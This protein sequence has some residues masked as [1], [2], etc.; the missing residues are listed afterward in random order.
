MTYINCKRAT[1]N[2]LTTKFCIISIIT[3]VGH[4]ICHSLARNSEQFCRLTSSIQNTTWCYYVWNAEQVVFTE[5]NVRRNGKHIFYTRSITIAIWETDP[6]H[7][8]HACGTYPLRFAL[9]LHSLN[10]TGLAHFWCFCDC[11]WC[12]CDL[13]EQIMA[14]KHFLFRFNNNTEGME[15]TSAGWSYACWRTSPHWGSHGWGLHV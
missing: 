9:C 2:N 14:M 11:S 4:F 10:Y 12:K 13:T 15:Y 7:R 3:G 5:A 1:P 6:G 8:I